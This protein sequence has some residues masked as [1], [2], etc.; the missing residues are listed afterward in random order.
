MAIYEPG[1]K[2]DLL[3]WYLKL[4]IFETFCEEQGLH[5]TFGFL[6]DLMLCLVAEILHTGTCRLNIRNIWAL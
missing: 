2:F 6:N 3:S 1:K 4:V 5:S